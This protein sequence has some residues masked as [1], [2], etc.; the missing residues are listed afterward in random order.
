ML[1]VLAGLAAAI[2][3]ASE[4]EL[5]EVSFWNRQARNAEGL[6]TQIFL[7]I[8]EAGA[9][10]RLG[11]SLGDFKGRFERD[12]RQRWLEYIG[13]FFAVDGALSII[14]TSKERIDQ[15]GVDDALVWIGSDGRANDI[16]VTET[17]RWYNW[18]VERGKEYAGE[19]T[20]AWYTMRDEKV[21]PT[22]F[23]MHGVTIP[24][25]EDF[26]LPTGEKVSGPP[27]HGRCR[28]EEQ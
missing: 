27:A 5:E 17:T 4:G 16:A 6:S 26:V 20:K 28:C 18:G 11:A 25:D 14:R 24:L 3:K 13:L 19:D 22:C 2:R 1:I 23:S 21:C 8:A 9:L 7:D 15:I 12:R 10:S